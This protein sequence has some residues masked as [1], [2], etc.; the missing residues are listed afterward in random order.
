[1]SLNEIVHVLDTD[2]KP[3]KVR[4]T[5]CIRPFYARSMFGEARLSTA[6]SKVARL[7]T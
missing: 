2:R 6:P 4:R 3:D 1:M 7:K 5:E